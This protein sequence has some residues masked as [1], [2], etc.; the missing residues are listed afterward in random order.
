MSWNSLFQQKALYTVNEVSKILNGPTRKAIRARLGPSDGTRLEK[1]RSLKAWYGWRVSLI[2]QDL[3]VESLKE[4]ESLMKSGDPFKERLDDLLEQHRRAEWT[5]ILKDLDLN[6]RYSIKVLLGVARCQG[7]AVND[8]Q[9]RNRINRGLRNFG[10]AKTYD[11][12]QGCYYYLGWKLRLIWADLTA[13]MARELLPYFPPTEHLAFQAVCER[14]KLNEPI[15]VGEREQAEGRAKAAE[16]NCLA[17]STKE[18]SAKE[19][20]QLPGLPSLVTEECSEEILGA[21]FMRNFFNV[22]AFLAVLVTVVGLIFAVQYLDKP[23]KP[24]SMLQ[25]INDEKFSQEKLSP[26]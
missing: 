11:G 13:E 10:F 22:R 2:Y 25:S 7:F 12:Q 6:N 5:V 8:N 23:S 1:K 20:F 18:V 14:F 4:C 9:V 24:T 19:D 17:Q 15:D 16:Q 21:P 3:D 26:P